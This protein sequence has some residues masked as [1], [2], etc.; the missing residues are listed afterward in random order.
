MF[1]YAFDY[2]EHI[3]ISGQES[4]FIRSLSKANK[5]ANPYTP[6]NSSLSAIRVRI[7]H[8]HVEGLDTLLKD[9]FGLCYA[10]V[11]I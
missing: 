11:Y 1:V 9:R 8:K 3:L 4:W 5:S 7:A 2:P 10:T 6:E